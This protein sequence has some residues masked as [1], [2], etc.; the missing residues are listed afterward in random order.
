MALCLLNLLIV[1]IVPYEVKNID[2]DDVVAYIYIAQYF[3]LTTSYILTLYM[4]YKT[5]EKT[6]DFGNFTTEHRS[7]LF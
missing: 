1:L 6:R 4:L 2:K 7:I 5:L 3:M